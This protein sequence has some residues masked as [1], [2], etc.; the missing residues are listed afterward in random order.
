MVLCFVWSVLKFVGFVKCLLKWLAMSLLEVA[1]WLLKLI[2]QL[3]SV[4]VGS[5]LFSD[6]IVSH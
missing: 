2:E 5:L 6:L 1:M 3:G 4:G